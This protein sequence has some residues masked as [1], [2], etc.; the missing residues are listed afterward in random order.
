M[1]KSTSLPAC[2]TECTQINLRD[3]PE[4]TASSAVLHQ[5]TNRPASCIWLP[6]AEL[7]RIV[8]SCERWHVFVACMSFRKPNLPPPPLAP[9]ILHQVTL[10]A[11]NI[12]EECAAAVCCV[13]MAWFH[14]K[15][16]QTGSSNVAQ[17]VA[18]GR[19]NQEQRR[20]IVHPSSPFA[21]KCSGSAVRGH[22]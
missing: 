2:Q 5:P 7:D 22:Q 8:H 11:Y 9:S 17:T 1:K 19:S 4:L 16:R 15:S 12:W 21:T 14:T 6:A 20:W 3:S 13:Y 10:T 18:I